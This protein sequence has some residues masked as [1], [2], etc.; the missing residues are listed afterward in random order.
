MSTENFKTLSLSW[1]QHRD[2]D[3]YT[4]TEYIYIYIYSILYALHGT[5]LV[6]NCDGALCANPHTQIIAEF[7]PKAIHFREYK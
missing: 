6:S 3:T 5:F 2:R 1:F 7:I 4:D